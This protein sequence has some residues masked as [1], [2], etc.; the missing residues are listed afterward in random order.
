MKN[1]R[2]ITLIELLAALALVFVI[3]SLVFSVFMSTQENYKQS[4]LKSSAHRQVNILLTQLTN[5]H[6]NSLYYTIRPLDESTIEINFSSP[7]GKTRSYVFDGKPFYFNLYIEKNDEMVRI[8]DEHIVDLTTRL[9][10]SLKITVSHNSPRFKPI[11]ITTN[12][13][14]LAPARSR[15]DYEKIYQ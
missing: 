4:E 12:L 13:S 15:W 2:G 14:R 5:I 3:G 7:S 8:T 11:E 9:N 10:I 6:Q 1:E